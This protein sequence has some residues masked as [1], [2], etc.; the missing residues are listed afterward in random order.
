MGGTGV[1][2]TDADS[3]PTGAMGQRYLA[4]GIA[5]SLRLWEQEP[6]GEDKAA[7]G[8]EYETVGYVLGGRAVLRAGTGADA[9]ELALAPGDT[10]VVPRGVLHTYVV[11]EAFSALEATSPPAQVAGRDA[12][13]G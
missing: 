13:E 4:S 8:R 2:K 9:V 6:S 1:H 5:V 11:E 10:W 12:P 7:V 3:S